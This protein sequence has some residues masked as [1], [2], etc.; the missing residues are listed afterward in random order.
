MDRGIPG[1]TTFTEED[2]VLTIQALQV[3]T[4]PLTVA[5]WPLLGNPDARTEI[6][7]RLGTAGRQLLTAL[8]PGSTDGRPGYITT[9]RDDVAEILLTD[10]AQPLSQLD[11][12]VL[13]LV[14][15]QSVIIP[16]AAGSAPA[17][18]LTTGMPVAAAALRQPGI[19]GRGI[20]AGDIEEA[21]TRLRALTLI[22]RDNRPGPAFARLSP[23]QQ[24]RLWGNIFELARPST[25]ATS[26]SR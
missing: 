24:D 9:W 23:Q 1:M 7:R 8:P 5:E 6:S 2:L 25:A 16:Q 17:H 14:M 19:D 26:Y 18:G 15:M 21:L 3:T 20:D 13:T 12:A 11:R 10:G 22:T 4:E